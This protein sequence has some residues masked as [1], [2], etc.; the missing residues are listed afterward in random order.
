MNQS[1]QIQ[2][3]A[4]RTPF[5]VVGPDAG[6]H[7]VVIVG[8]GAG[9]LELATSLGDKLG[10]KGLVAVTLIEKVT[11]PFLEATPARN[12]GRQYGPQYL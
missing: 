10:K 12:R 3:E 7:Q 11:H 4:Q 1:T 2:N 6:L 5:N 8:G 9:G